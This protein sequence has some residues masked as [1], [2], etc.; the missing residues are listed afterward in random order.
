MLKALESNL[1]IDAPHGQVALDP[2]THHCT[3]DMYLA[4]VRD[5]GYRVLDKSRAVTAIDMVGQC[6]L[7]K[8]PNTNQQFEPRI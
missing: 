8:N 3:Y 7:V 5:G 6:D 1:S 2:A 4:E